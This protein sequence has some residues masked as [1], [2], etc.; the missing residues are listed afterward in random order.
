MLSLINSWIMRASPP[1]YITPKALSRPILLMIPM[2]N[3]S[4]HFFSFFLLSVDTRPY[5]YRTG[6]IIPISFFYL[7]SEEHLDNIISFPILTGI[8]GTYPILTVISGTYPLLTGIERTFPILT[9]ISGTYPI[10]TG[11]SGTYPIVA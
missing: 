3:S 1:L 8:S 4:F 9:G 2:I 11:I 7:S 10:L 5:L 6:I